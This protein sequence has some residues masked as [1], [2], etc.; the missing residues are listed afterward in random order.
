MNLPKTKS[1]SCKEYESKLESICF[2][3]RKNIRKKHEIF[4]ENRCAEVVKGVEL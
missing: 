4:V 2:Q 3:K 1:V